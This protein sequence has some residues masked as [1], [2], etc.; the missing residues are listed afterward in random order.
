[1]CNS[2]DQDACAASDANKLNSA[3]NDKILGLLDLVPVVH[4]WSKYAAFG[5]MIVLKQQ[6]AS[7]QGIIHSS[8][9]RSV[10]CG[11]HSVWR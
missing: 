5:M 7:G 2:L 1:M 11:D 9:V 4:P 8:A 6:E 10:W 3:V